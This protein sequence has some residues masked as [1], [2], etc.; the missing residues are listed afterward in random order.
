MILL[1]LNYEILE[2]ISL[3]VRW[4]NYACFNN[5]IKIT[6]IEFNIWLNILIKIENSYL[7]TIN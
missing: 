4:F 7:V 2:E 5:P 3:T 1:N 6:P